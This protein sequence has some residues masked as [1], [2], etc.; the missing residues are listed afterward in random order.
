LAH[1][2]HTPGL[3]EIEEQ[4]HWELAGVERGVQKVRAEIEAQR[5]GDSQLGYALAQKAVPPLIEKIKEAQAEAERH[6]AE[7]AGNTGRRSPWW[8]LILMLPADKLAV[9]TIKRVMATPPRDF[10]F[11]HALTSLAGQINMSVIDQLEY[12]DM[13]GEDKKRIDRFFQNYALTPRNLKRLRER[14]DRQRAERWSTDH[15]IQLGVVLLT[16]LTQA[17][18]EWFSISS[19]RLRSGRWEYQF[20]ISEAARDV[21][22]RLSEQC[23]LTQPALMPTITPPADWRIAA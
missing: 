6:L 3:A 8:Y 9:I 22:F 17:V 20:I 1:F 13:R 14:L 18:P 21:L 11:N 12:E 5:V 16:L 4:K 15:G 7:A 19:Q 23:E 10:T 2:W